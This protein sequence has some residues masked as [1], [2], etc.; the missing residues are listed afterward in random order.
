MKRFITFLIFGA[1]L[2]LPSA[3]KAEKFERNISLTDGP[4]FMPKGEFIF[5]GTISYN[6]FNFD[7]YQFIILE[8]MDLGTSSFSVSP[9]LYYSF[10]NNMAVGVRFA[11]TRSV[12]DLG[13]TDL[14]LS[15]DLQFSIKDMYNIQQT[16]YGS[17]AYRYYMPIGN[18]LRFG[19]F[20]DI[21]LSIGAGEGKFLSGTGE[22]MSGYYQKIFDVGIDVVPGVVVFLSNSVSVQASVGVL[23]LSYK[24][25]DQIKNQVYEGSYS[26]KGADFKINFLSIGL[27]INF[28]I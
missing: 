2:L 13:S 21:M 17:A 22:E 27:G 8:G 7:D 12:I 23:G 14:A 9:N 18:S 20:A 16:Y 5:G 4:V 15:D 19:L 3:A 24:K 28:V 25:I 10:A 1:L 6:S 26:K 11:Y